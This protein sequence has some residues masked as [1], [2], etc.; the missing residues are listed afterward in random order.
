MLF[1][2]EERLETCFIL[3]NVMSE[4]CLLFYSGLISDFILAECNIFSMSY[5]NNLGR[6]INKVRGK[7]VGETHKVAAQ[8]SC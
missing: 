2:P 6:H 4:K 5:Q 1:T 8:I 7:V 3:I